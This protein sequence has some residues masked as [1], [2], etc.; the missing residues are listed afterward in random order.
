MKLLFENWRRFITEQTGVDT[1]GDGYPDGTVATPN[2]TTAGPMTQQ[3]YDERVRAAQLNAISVYQDSYRVGQNEQ[4]HGAGTLSWLDYIQTDLLPGT[5]IEPTRENALAY[6]TEHITP[7][8]N[9]VL[10]PNKIVRHTAIP[11]SGEIQV[12]LD[13]GTRGYAGGA[14]YDEA[15]SDM[16]TGIRIDAASRSGAALYDTMGHEYGHV[17][18]M[19]INPY[20][21]I[22]PSTT[23]ISVN[24]LIRHASDEHE[25]HSAFWGSHRAGYDPGSSEVMRAGAA[26]MGL[27]PDEPLDWNTVGGEGA[28]DMVQ[29]RLDNIGS[30]SM[31]QI[32]NKR[33]EAAFG[34]DLSHH[35]DE[36]HHERHWEPYAGLIWS[37]AQKSRHYD[38]LTVGVDNDGDGYPDAVDPDGDYIDPDPTV[39][40]TTDRAYTE[41]N[42][43]TGN[44]ENTRRH[45]AWDAQQMRDLKSQREDSEHGSHPRDPYGGNPDD[46]ED[47]PVPYN[48][49]QTRDVDAAAYEHGPGSEV[50]DE[51]YIKNLNTIADLGDEE[52]DEW[53]IDGE[54]SYSVTAEQKIFNN[55]RKF[56]TEAQQAPHQIYC[57][58]DGVLVDFVR[59]AIKQIN[60][61][62]NNDK[63]PDDV[64]GSGSL[65]S[66]GQL[67]MA[68]RREDV[69][70]IEEEHIEKNGDGSTTIRK[71]AIKYMY[72]RLRDDED[73]WANLP[74]MPGGRELWNAIKKYEPMIL[75]APMGKGSERGK[76]KWIAKNL[77]P[78]PKQV[79]MSHDKYEWAMSDGQRNVLIDD[80]MTNIKPW[81]S[82]GGIA[83]HHDPEDM[84]HTMDKLTQAGFKVLRAPNEHMDDEAPVEDED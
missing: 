74:W 47:N 28:L 37:R 33:M 4:E 3:Q 64:G 7:Q 35:G 12:G 60:D 68:M 23:G 76:E 43:E 52:E 18:G 27:D 61:D 19:N 38:D 26:K 70:V 80:F 31:D 50:S 1:D 45:T 79:F 44:W 83:I 39:T 42:P 82:H 10:D 9:S 72:E 53:S 34:P 66:L 56:L 46:P 62:V 75:T 58:M 21:G 54:S 71:A 13:G 59:G 17:L 40:T 67:R 81:K 24:W 14:Y 11:E 73:F 36:E 30:Q 51:E 55:W 2:A 22:D 41:F 57:D 78:S 8:I 84:K 49:F 63:L 20:A 77:R 15:H 25:P 16:D 48:T 5:S 65:N 32:H 6:Y 29:R 69:D